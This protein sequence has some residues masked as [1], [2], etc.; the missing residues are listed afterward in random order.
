MV[1]VVSLATRLVV[2]LAFW[3]TWTWQYG[4][5]HD[6]WN[7]LAI[8]WVTFGT[9]GYTAN[10]PTIQ[11]GPFFPI[12]EIPL[13]LL[14]GERYAGWSIVLLLLDTCTT[15]LLMFL[16]RRLWGDRAAWLAG[17]F[18]SVCLPVAYYSA[19]IEQFTT[20]V[21]FVF[22][23]LYLVSAWDRGL[24]SRHRSLTL[25][26][27]SGILVLSKSVY[28]PVVVGSALALVWLKARKHAAKAVIW[29]SAA[30]LLTASLVVLPWTY[31]NYIVTD[32]K[33]IP[34]QS[35]LWEIVWQRFVIS[36]LDAQEGWNRPS[37]RTLEYILA[38]QAALIR[39]LGE[40]DVARLSGPRKEMYY[41]Q[42]FKGQVL[43]WIRAKPG[44]YMRNVLN[45]V[46]SFWVGAENQKKTLL[47]AIMQVPPL[48][49]ALL[50]L[51]LGIRY[52]QLHK[53]R[54][55]LG[56]VLILWGEYSLVLGWG[57]FSLD[58]VP[59]LAFVFGAGIDAWLTHKTRRIPGTLAARTL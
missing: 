12:L 59:V 37:G 57:R 3:P 42:A 9:F 54:F 31:R 27:V 6:D 4:H 14:F 50:G 1:A 26:L 35:L 28:L 48:A 24:P 46:W 43:V 30:M 47:M 7:K 11:R 34:V 20:V 29:K 33:F 51:W 41:E 5:V 49:A 10:E 13:Y 2:L 15:I 17:L 44:A 19:Q 39:S 8:N 25:G 36:D 16:G 38:R 53:L 52:R 58:T 45:N 56:L 32:G 22:L 23:W 18:H 40:Q 21:P 55:G